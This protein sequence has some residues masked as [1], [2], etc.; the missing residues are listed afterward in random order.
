MEIRNDDNNI[1]KRSEN[2]NLNYDRAC[3]F[4]SVCLTSN[5]TIWST[6]PR[7][8]WNSEFVFQLKTSEMD[9][10]AKVLSFLI[11]FNEK[12]QRCIYLQL[13]SYKIGEHKVKPRRTVE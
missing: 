12:Q 6:Y 4:L 3:L 9:D 1:N 2:T 11:I 10:L 13:P 7:N 8:E 5:R